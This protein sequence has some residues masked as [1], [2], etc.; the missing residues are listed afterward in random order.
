MTHHTK[1]S[2]SRKTLLSATGIGLVACLG[3]E[4]ATQAA[5]P[6][7]SPASFKCGLLTVPFGST[8]PSDAPI[9]SNQLD[10]DCFGWWEFIALN[11]PSTQ[12]SGFGN[13]SDQNPVQWETY[14]SRELLF[15]PGA[16][17]PPPWGAQPAIPPDCQSQAQLTAENTKSMRLIQAISKFTST[18]A[19]E[20]DFPNSIDEAAPTNAPNWLGAQ[21]GT[22]VWY[23]VRINQD[24][25]NY[26]VSNQFYNANQQAA[27]VNNGNGQ[28]IIL[29]KG[30]LQSSAPTGA[31]EIK[32]AWLEVAD[33]RNTKWQ[34]YKLSPAVVVD[35]SS[36]TCRSTTVALVGFHIIHKT[37]SQP[38]WIWA[39]FEHVDNVPGSSS[40]SGSYNFYNSNCQPQQVQVPASCLP[41]GATSPVTVSCTPNT[42]PPYYLGNG[43]PGPVPIQV[44]RVVPIDSDAQQ[45]NSIAQAA[46]AKAFPKSVWQNYQLVNVIWSTSPTQDP[47]KPAQVPLPLS[48][49]QP[50][51]K[52]ANVVLETYMQN[53]TC[54]DCHRYATI[55]PT[56]ENSNPHW[57]ADFSFAIGSAAEPPSRP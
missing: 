14:M 46:I 40:S 42:P 12:G 25:Y 31:I 52:V 34:R 15:Q 53:L 50:P 45:A 49:M 6:S 47:K 29:P 33:P 17:T 9:L 48:S 21:N 32:A 3:P 28:P 37:Q 4:T 8:V 22:N 1:K 11:W 36:N 18:F 55:A 56:A 13:P 38:T 41:S 26:V 2:F 24:E 27:W 57:D 19:T 54:T 20:F 35:P 51:Q 5:A 43:C 44:S 7:I 23:E 39:T 30:S 16:A 10:A